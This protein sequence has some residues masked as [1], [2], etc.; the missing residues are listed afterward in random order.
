MLWRAMVAMPAMTS[1]WTIP[2]RHDHIAIHREPKGPSVGYRDRNGR[3][4]KPIDLWSSTSLY[5]LVGKRE[6]LRWDFDAGILAVFKLITN[7]LVDD[8]TPCRRTNNAFCA[9]KVLSTD[10]SDGSNYD[11]AFWALT[12]ASLIGRWGQAPSDYPPSQ[13]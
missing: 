6:Q 3:R 10:V 12:S 5:D 9:A 4:N 7:Y 13:C 1:Q 2:A 8:I 11:L